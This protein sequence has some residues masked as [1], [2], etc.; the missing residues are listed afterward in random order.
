MYPRVIVRYNP[1]YVFFSNNTIKQKHPQTETYEII[2][3]E[4]TRNCGVSSNRT[5]IEKKTPPVEGQRLVD[6]S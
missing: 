6:R 1:L 3:R 4:L 5:K 2:A